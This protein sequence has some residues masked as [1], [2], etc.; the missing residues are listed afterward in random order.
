MGLVTLA[1]TFNKKV[2]Y[3]CSYGKNHVDIDVSEV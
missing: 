2:S 1:L 3:V